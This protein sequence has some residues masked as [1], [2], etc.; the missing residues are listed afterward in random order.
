[1]IFRSLL[2]GLLGIALS[3]FGLGAFFLYIFP[4]T[5][6][7]TALVYAIPL[8]IM[9]SSIIIP[10]VGRLTGK[11]REFMVYESTFSDILGIMVFYFM[12][13][14]DGGAGE[15]SIAWE[16]VLNIFSTVVLSV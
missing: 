1:M 16:I 5:D 7:Y 15:G 12:I 14:A 11:K 9:S 10:S 6:F 2:G 13:G 3:M 8:S 4:S